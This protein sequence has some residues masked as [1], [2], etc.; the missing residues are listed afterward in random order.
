MSFLVIF[1][2]LGFLLYCECGDYHCINDL[3]KDT[4]CMIEVI[5]N[6]LRKIN[7]LIVSEGKFKRTL[8]I[9]WSEIQ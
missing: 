5:N 2:F 1:S 7:T 8:L 6:L 4:E 9:D 3:L